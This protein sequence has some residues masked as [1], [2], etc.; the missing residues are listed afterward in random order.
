MLSAVSQQHDAALDI[1]C[2]NGIS[3]A[4]LASY[5]TYVEG[6]DLGENMIEKARANYPGLQFSACAAEEFDSR[7][8]YDLIT[9]ATS[10]YCLLGR[11]CGRFSVG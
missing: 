11:I 4:R 6:I 7:H 8:R 9:S 3:T 10:F 1:G 2:G 5:F